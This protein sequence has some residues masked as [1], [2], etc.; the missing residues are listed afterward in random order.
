MLSAPFRVVRPRRECA[1]SVHVAGH[2]AA[3]RRGGI[4]P[5]ILVGADPRRGDAKP[6]RAWRHDGRAGSPRATP[7]AIG[8]VAPGKRR[9]L[10]TQLWIIKLNSP[11]RPRL[12]GAV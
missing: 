5:G 4:L 6:D 2:V 1:L 3:R 11:S 8:S 9:S 10:P 12:L 7:L